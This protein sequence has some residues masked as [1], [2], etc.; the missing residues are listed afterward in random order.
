[1]YHQGPDRFFMNFR[2]IYVIRKEGEF[3]EN[4]IITAQDSGQSFV[5]N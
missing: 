5:L 2:L 1:M 4:D 3:Q